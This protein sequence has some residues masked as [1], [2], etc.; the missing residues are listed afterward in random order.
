MRRKISFYV[1]VLRVSARWIIPFVLL[2]L[3]SAVSPGQHNYR[4]R[5]RK[6]VE[7][8]EPNDSGEYSFEELLSKRQEVIG[9]EPQTLDASE[10]GQLAWAG[11]GANSE[12]DMQ[13]PSDSS[14]II[15]LYFATPNGLFAYD[16]EEHNLEE[17][18][19]RDV[20]GL[21]AEAA[22]AEPSIA[23]AGCDILIAG[24]IREVALKH[25]KRG[26]KRLYFE[27]GHAAEK[28]RLQAESLDLGSI[29]VGDFETRRVESAC[30]LPR[31]HRPLYIVGVG[32]PIERSEVSLSPF[33]QTIHRRAV[34]VVATRDFQDNEFFTT[35][36]ILEGAGIKTDVASSRRGFLRGMFGSRIE[37][38]YRLGELN[39]E[40]YDALIFIGGVGATELFNN[41]AAHDVA[42]AAVDAGKVVGA[43]G[44]SP[45]ILAEAGL[46]SGVRVTSM[47]SERSR[48]TNAGAIYTGAPLERNGKIITAKNP[49][50]AGNF[51]HS[52]LRALGGR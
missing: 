9:F 48:L 30:Q 15:K 21:L 49:R 27:A 35:K 50:M 52:I 10:L 13:S 39:P 3:L 45:S 11:Q 5:S 37:S 17:V 24:L 7:L 26:E 32:H 19:E 2:L 20:R 6:I 29:A 40:E 1:G 43:I 4:T 36:L 12:Q 31:G 22:G 23:Q 41:Q 38:Q 42:R 18:V 46:L 28:I 25:G 51:A 47:L 14:D 34:L 16:S 33:L 44:L 8:P